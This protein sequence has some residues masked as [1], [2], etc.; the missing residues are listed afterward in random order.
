MK[1]NQIRNTFILLSMCCC[2]YALAATVAYHGESIY[3]FEQGSFYKKFNMKLLTDKETPEGYLYYY[4]TR[5]FTR[6]FNT[7]SIAIY[8]DFDD[9][10]NKSKAVSGSKTN[11]YD[12]FLTHLC[13]ATTYNCDKK[14]QETYKKFLISWVR[15]GYKLYSA[16]FGSYKLT[17]ER[18]KDGYFAYQTVQ[19]YG[20]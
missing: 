20:N 9:I 12:F 10:I 7:N 16:K 15:N 3:G 14:S 4:E 17:L 19:G 6:T 1:R 11:F 2:I 5:D 8:T 18:A 13:A